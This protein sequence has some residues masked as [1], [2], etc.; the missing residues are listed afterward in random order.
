MIL[1]YAGRTIQFEHW[2]VSSISEYGSPR[3]TTAAKLLIGMSIAVSCLGM[4]SVLLS[5]HNSE[6]HT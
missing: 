5:D 2:V 1:C 3:G 6:N 4:A